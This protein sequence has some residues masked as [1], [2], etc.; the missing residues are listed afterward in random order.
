MT[1]TTIFLS[2]ITGV[3]IGMGVI[4]LSIKA[5]EQVVS[6]MPEPPKPVKGKGG[7]KNG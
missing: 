4:Y 2:G 3:F 1:A 5:I 7:K 6:R